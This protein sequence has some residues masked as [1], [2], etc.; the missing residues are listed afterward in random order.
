M[1][2]EYVIKV[3]ARLV[4]ADDLYPEKNMA[5]T[6]L[7]LTA[8]GDPVSSGCSS[9][10]ADGSAAALGWLLIGLALVLRRKI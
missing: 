4:F 2:G 7:T 6:Q 9:T 8:E 3:S 1:P 5:S 10:S